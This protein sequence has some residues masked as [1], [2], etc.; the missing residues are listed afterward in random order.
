MI[1]LAMANLVPKILKALH[2]VEK[3][4]LILNAVLCYEKDS[5]CWSRTQQREP[6]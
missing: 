4:G 6:D 2:A 1:F 3:S 5:Y